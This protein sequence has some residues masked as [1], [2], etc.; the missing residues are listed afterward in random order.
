MKNFAQKKVTLNRCAQ[1]ATKHA[2]ENNKLAHSPWFQLSFF[3]Y[4]CE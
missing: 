1:T 3:C 2:C 4:I